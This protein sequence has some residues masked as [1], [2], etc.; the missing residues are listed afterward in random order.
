[1]MSGEGQPVGDL[2]RFLDVAKLDG[3]KKQTCRY[4]NNAEGIKAVSGSEMEEF[5]PVIVSR[6]SA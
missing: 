6:Q 2:L 3:G 1:M 5:H 4:R